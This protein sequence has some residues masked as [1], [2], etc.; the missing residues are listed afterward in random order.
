MQIEERDE[1]ILVITGDKDGNLDV[2][3]EVNVKKINDLKKNSKV[4]L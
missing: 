1:L 4:I 2:V 3:H